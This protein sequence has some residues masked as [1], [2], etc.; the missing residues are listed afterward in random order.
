MTPEEIAQKIIG[1]PEFQSFMDT[2]LVDG[3]V[4]VEGSIQDW[5]DCGVNRFNEFFVLEEMAK[6]NPC[7]DIG[8][9]HFFTIFANQEAM[10]DYHA[11]L[12]DRQTMACTYLCQ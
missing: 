8:F 7:I 12:D 4:S 11:M 3:A 2:N 1:H 9:G 10:D 6:L 5:E